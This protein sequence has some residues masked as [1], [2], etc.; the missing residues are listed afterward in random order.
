MAGSEDEAPRLDADDLVNVLSCI[1][2]GEG[3]DERGQSFGVAQQ[4]GDVIEE[5]AGLGEVGDVAD[6]G[7]EVG[8]VGHGVLF[9]TAASSF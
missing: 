1:V 9:I 7:L 8:V 4:R 3:V 2:I 6:E 5:D